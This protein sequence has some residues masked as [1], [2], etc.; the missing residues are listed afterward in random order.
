MSTLEEIIFSAEE[1]GKRD[2]LFIEVGRIK[3]RESGKHLHLTDIYQEAYETVMK[4]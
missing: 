2:Q 1:H 3:Q 4:M